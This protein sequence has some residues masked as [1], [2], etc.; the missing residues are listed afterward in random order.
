VVTSNDLE[1]AAHV[2]NIH[3]HVMPSPLVK[4]ATPP[5]AVPILS[6]TALNRI[7]GNLEPNPASSPMLQTEPSRNSSLMLQNVPDTFSLGFFPDDVAKTSTGHVI[8]SAQSHDVFVNCPGNLCWGNPTPNTFITDLGTSNFVHL[9][10]QYSG[11]TANNRYTLGKTV[12]VTYS[13]LFSN[14]LS[15][16]DILGIVHAAAVATGKLVGY[17]HIYH[18]FLP[19]G[20]DTCFDPF[21]FGGGCYSPDNPS[22]FVFCAYHE[23]VTFSDIGHVIYSVEPF[24]GPITGEPSCAIPPGSP[25][26]QLIDSTSTSLLHEFFEAV[27]DPD[28][29]TGFTVIRVLSGS[30][31]SAMYA[32]DPW[33]SP[34][35]PVAI[36]RLSWCIRI[37]RMRAQTVRSRTA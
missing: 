10:D 18:V 7:L 34:C 24:Q 20:I 28:P 31:R 33:V 2:S 30:W 3:L 17:N 9:L 15:Q 11:S 8:L 32:T 16:N 22:T 19:K 12:T 13:P 6:P 37:A 5:A 4:S 1:A 14:T 36:T 29:S 25:N 35:S 21:P 27:S 23:S 26:G